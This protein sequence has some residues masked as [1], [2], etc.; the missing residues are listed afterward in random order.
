[1]EQ[2]FGP[3]A[4]FRKLMEFWEDTKIWK[5]NPSACITHFRCMSQ[6]W[7]CN[8]L[9]FPVNLGCAPYFDAVA[10]VTCNWVI[11]IFVAVAWHLNDI[12]SVVNKHNYSYIFICRERETWIYASSLAIDN[13]SYEWS[14]VLKLCYSPHSPSLFINAA[15]TYKV[16]FPSE[17]MIILEVVGKE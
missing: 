13:P 14:F 2:L 5:K 9:F 3:V 4:S 8:W 11:G 6:K 1:M 17:E 10:D 15:F 16:E 7:N 12:F